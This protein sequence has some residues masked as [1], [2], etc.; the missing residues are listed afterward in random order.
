MLDIVDAVKLAASKK[1]KHPPGIRF[2]E[3]T[4][5]V[6]TE[7]DGNDAEVSSKP[8]RTRPPVSYVYKGPS[9]N[10]SSGRRFVYV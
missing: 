7:P 9:P 10:N 1:G 6:N 2:L 5:I 4:D 8:Q 3:A